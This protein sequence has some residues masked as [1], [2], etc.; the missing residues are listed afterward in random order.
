MK[1]IIATLSLTL[2]V[3]F[4]FAQDIAGD[5][6]GKLN[7]PGKALPVIFHLKKGE[8]GYAAT[9]DSPDQ[10]AMGMV[11]DKV[12]FSENRLVL[13]YDQLK[14]RFEGIH[15][16]DSNKISGTF[17]QGTYK[18]PMVLSPDQSSA[19]V[20]KVARPQDPKDFPYQQEEV[21]FTN[22]KGGHQL[23]GTLTLP[24]N[25][26]ASKIVILIT[27]SGAQN[28]DEEIVEFNH[29][30]FLVL[31]DWLT[32]NGIAVLR[33]DDRGT[34]KSTGNFFQATT[35]DFA[36]D[37]EAAVNFIGSRPD[38]KKLSLG[39]VGHSEGGMIAPI[40]AARNKAVKF[41]VLL[42]GPGIASSQVMR[43][44]SEDMKKV[45]QNSDDTIVMGAYINGVV[46]SAI[47][48]NPDSSTEVLQHKIDSAFNKGLAAY[49][50]NND[51]TLADAMIAKA[52]KRALG[53]WFR[54]FAK[55]NAADYIAKVKCPTLA[56]NGT[57]DLQVKSEPNLAGIKSA[58]EKAGN[59]HFEI[60]P[61]PNLNHFFQKAVTGSFEEYAVLTETFNPE[62]LTKVSTWINR[63]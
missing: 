13:T 50:K 33:Y 59:K 39:L 37:V 40:V 5:W 56:L 45:T 26:K 8:Q 34:A 14:I 46:F 6:Y 27:G 30:P 20:V 18:F 63:L 21:L 36:D 42:A 47:L 55:F 53:P 38:L 12:E 35:A 16:A 11:I 43:Q 60:V 58:L 23:A 15:Q 24:S 57:L 48:D 17:Q 19:K 29:R 25:G 52:S 10:G 44:Q 61:M 51:R 1:R 2:F 31:S 62:A 32:R 3:S 41:M 4:S 22:P 54:Y 7:I 49:L 9:M 28:R